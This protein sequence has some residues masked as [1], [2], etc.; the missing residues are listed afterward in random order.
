[1]D[2]PL[3]DGAKLGTKYILKNGYTGLFDSH[4]S[5]SDVFMY[6]HE[7]HKV[8]I[9]TADGICLDSNTTNLDVKERMDWRQLTDDDHTL[10]LADEY[11]EEERRYIRSVDNKIWNAFVVGYRTRA[12][13]EQNG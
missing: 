11:V 2:K 8:L 9:Y 3:F 5:S 1:M 10:K 6:I 13:E 12:K 4:T 7:M